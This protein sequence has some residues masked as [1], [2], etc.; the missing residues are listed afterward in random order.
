MK[1]L[2]L[3]SLAC[4]LAAGAAQADTLDPLEPPAYEPDPVPPA[5]PENSEPPAPP[6]G[7][8][9]EF[10]EID[11]AWRWMIASERSMEELTD[12][13]FIEELAEMVTPSKLEVE[14]IEQVL[15]FEQAL[16]DCDH[17][18]FVE[19]NIVAAANPIGYVVFHFRSRDLNERV[20]LGYMLGGPVAEHIKLPHVDGG[21]EPLGFDTPFDGF[22]EQGAP[23]QPEPPPS[24]QVNPVPEPGAAAALLTGAVLL[25]R[26]RRLTTA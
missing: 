4:L 19:A 20:R 7:M 13:E 10:P 26:R 8:P 1:H 12:P 11:D 24:P 5:N 3:I 21:S 15:T 2:L 6:T 16:L 14:V 17:D 23:E 22:D 9:D 25:L 18:G